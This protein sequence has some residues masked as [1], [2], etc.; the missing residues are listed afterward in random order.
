MK[1]LRYILLITY[2]LAGLDWQVVHL[3]RWTHPEYKDWMHAHEIQYAFITRTIG[4]IACTPCMALKPIAYQMFMDVQASQAEQDNILHAPKPTVYGFYQLI[5]RG[6]PWT[7]TP[8][9]AWFLYWIPF[10]LLWKRFIYDRI[11]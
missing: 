5:K 4:A 1:I 3:T 2:L 9:V 8:W 7:F 11:A 10:T 6:E